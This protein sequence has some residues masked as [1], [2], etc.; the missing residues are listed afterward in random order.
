MA[1]DV[2]FFDHSGDIAICC[3]KTGSQFCGRIGEIAPIHA[4]EFACR[5]RDLGARREVQLLPAY[6]LLDSMD[7]GEPIK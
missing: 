3:G 6:K 7:A 2:S 4:I 1:I 5:P